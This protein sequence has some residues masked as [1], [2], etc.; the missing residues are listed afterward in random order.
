MRKLIF[1]WFLAVGIIS[2]IAGIW[3]G[4]SMRL[5]AGSLYESEFIHYTAETLIN[6]LDSGG[7]PALNDIE[8]RIDSGRKLRFFVFD[9]SLRELSGRTGAEA[10]RPLAAKLRPQE[11]TRF[12]VTGG[13]LLAGRMVTAHD[14]RAYGVI[15][16]FPARRI[17]N[18]PVYAWGW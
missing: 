8:S 6:G 7:I 15:I 13:G 5:A 17:A 9:S 12:E 18:V 14:G 10:V 11:G 16:R 1:F 2:T 3:I 4:R